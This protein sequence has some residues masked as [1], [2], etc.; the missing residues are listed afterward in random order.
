[1]DFLK[2]N[3]TLI[4][5]RGESSGTSDSLDAVE[6]TTTYPHSEVSAPVH[7]SEGQ[8]A[9]DGGTSKAPEVIYKNY[10]DFL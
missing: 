1:M 2:L 9:R 10:N 4:R 8:D 5:N 3:F 7:V 6:S